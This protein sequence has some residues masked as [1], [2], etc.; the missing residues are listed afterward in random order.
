MGDAERVC[1]VS[2]GSL[3]AFVHAAGIRVR[4]LSGKIRT[5][6][7]IPFRRIWPKTFRSLPCKGWWGRMTVTLSGASMW[8]VWRNVLRPR[9]P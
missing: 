4:L 6:Y 3:G 5:R 7:R 9:V 8:V 2:S 1:F